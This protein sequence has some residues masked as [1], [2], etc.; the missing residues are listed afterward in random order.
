MQSYFAQIKTLIDQYAAT[1][2]VLEARISFE[3]RPG[4]QGYLVGSVTFLDNSILHFKEFL[5]KTG[6]VTDK[7]MFSYHYQDADHQLI[8]RYDNARH[9][10]P[11][12]SPEHKHL[13]EE[14]IVASAPILADV[15][16]EIVVT[17]GWV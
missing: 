2:F 4:N 6:E 17:K 7:L 14:V 8:F 3:L 16:T 10:P 5:D 1:S 12:T 13:P 15:L 11:L 9:K